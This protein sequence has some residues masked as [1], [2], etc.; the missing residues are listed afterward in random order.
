MN[1]ADL[2]ALAKILQGLNAPQQSATPDRGNGGGGGG[3][4][5]LRKSY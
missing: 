3:V 2:V 5:V 4:K 1:E